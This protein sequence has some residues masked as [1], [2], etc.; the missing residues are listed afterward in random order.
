MND[1][2]VPPIVRPGV[3]S[4]EAKDEDRRVFEMTLP[5]GA[6]PETV[7]AALTDA[8]ALAAWFPFEAE[9]T[10]GAGG[11][12]RWSWP[13][14]MHWVVRIMQ[15]E[16][17]RHLRLTYDHPQGPQLAIEYFIEGREGGTVL[18]LVHSGFGRGGDWDAEFDAISTGW[19]YE[20]RVLRLYLERHRGR[21]R[22]NA[23]A[24]RGV[25]I[26]LQAAFERVL[27]AMGAS[28]V[29]GLAE[30]APCR[31]AAPNGDLFT[32]EVLVVH[33]RQFAVT[34]DRRGGAL[35][36]VLAEEM[37]D[38]PQVWVVLGAWD[39]D[40]AASGAFEVRWNAVLASL[41]G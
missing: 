13:P 8:K 33:P 41:F 22:I 6:T 14:N 5:I 27:D 15:W 12:Q 18:R 23:L 29:R 26:P 37:P 20:L 25:M 21:A 4:T 10:P 9:A 31:I 1:H 32:G 34:L 35:L 17:A 36:R 19:P 40:Q 2:S 3:A 28:H 39:G 38:G 11:T 24:R 30:G 16:P 7:F